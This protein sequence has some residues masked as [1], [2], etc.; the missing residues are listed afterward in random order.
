MLVITERERESDWFGFGFR[1]VSFAIEFSDMCI[2][3]VAG[4]L[5]AIKCRCVPSVDMTDKPA[6]PNKNHP[7]NY[8]EKIIK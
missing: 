5:D 7:Q 8:D 6:K 4:G 2:C 1:S 3:F